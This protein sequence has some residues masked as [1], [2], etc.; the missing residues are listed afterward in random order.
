VT[1]KAVLTHPLSV[2]ALGLAAAGYLTAV[3]PARPGHYPS[4]PFH[5]LTGKYCPGCGGLRALHDLLHGQL[6][7]AISS[8]LLVVL[9]LPVVVGL[10]AVWTWG[11]LSGSGRA[12]RVRTPTW[13]WV[14]LGAC[15][16]VFGVLRNLPASS[17]LAP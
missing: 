11:R 15:M 6:I 17:W 13:L 8:N 16:L 10:W 9:A 14:A 7:A 2:G 4:C 12:E 5:L 1:Q 3:D